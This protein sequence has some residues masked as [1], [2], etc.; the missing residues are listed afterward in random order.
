MVLEQDLLDIWHVGGLWHILVSAGAGAA[1]APAGDAV[2]EAEEPV[3]ELSSEAGHQ[4]YVRVAAV[5]MLYI[6]PGYLR[7]SQWSWSWSWSASK[8]GVG[9]RDGYL[10][11][12]S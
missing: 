9:V 7:D 1:A 8:N 3:L 10:S 5:F 12:L 6:L 4:A 2:D 11:S